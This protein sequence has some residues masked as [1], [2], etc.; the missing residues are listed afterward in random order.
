M[1]NSIDKSLDENLYDFHNF[2][3]VHEEGDKNKKELT[4]FLGPKSDRNTKKITWT[5][6]IPDSVLDGRQRAADI[7]TPNPRP[8]S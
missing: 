2:G 3:L 7:P 8:M 4:A 6:K 1:V 5:N